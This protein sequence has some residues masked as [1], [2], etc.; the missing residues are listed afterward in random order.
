[1]QVV[2]LLAGVVDPKWR[3]TSL[4]EPNLPRKLSPF[5]EA[6]L[7]C[8]LKLRDA[9]PGLRLTAVLVG[10][11]ELDA[12]A[13]AAAAF[14]PHRVF[15][16]DA[17]LPWDPRAALA[18]LAAAARAAAP[19]SGLVLIGREFGDTDDGVL[20]AALAEAEGWRYGGLAHAVALAGDVAV[21]Q[22]SRGPRAETLRLPL[23][24]LASITN[25]R[26]NR[27]RHPL[28]KNVILAKREPVAVVTP[29]IPA[30]EPML[31][32]RRH[33]LVPPPKRGSGAC[34]LLDGPLEAQAEELLGALRGAGS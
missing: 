31:A 16:F 18:L 23:P 13:R 27:L 14:R 29:A 5:D 21:L 9:D 17:A 20:P 2:V 1:M 34:R 19:E 30:P 11:A 28:M 6:A 26:G 8:G 33:A 12:L 32:L 24:A 22:R 25:D 10:G 3:L 15:R 7:E 4:A